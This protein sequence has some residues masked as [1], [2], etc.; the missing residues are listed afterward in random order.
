MKDPVYSLEQIQ[1][2]TALKKDGNVCL[3]PFRTPYFT[4]SQIQGQMHI[5]QPIC[6]SGCMFFSIYGNK[7]IINEK[8]KKMVL[9]SCVKAQFYID[10]DE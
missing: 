6:S 5:N 2:V 4:P 8:E 9:L 10:G 7:L 1:G 3:C